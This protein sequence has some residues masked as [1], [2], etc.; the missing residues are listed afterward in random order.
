MKISLLKSHPQTEYILEFLERNLRKIKVETVDEIDGKKTSDEVLV[1]INGEVLTADTGYHMLKEIKSVLKKID[2]KKFDE[3]D[4][5]KFKKSLKAEKEELLNTDGQE[6]EEDGLEERQSLY[7]QAG[8]LLETAGKN[9]YLTLDSNVYDPEITTI[10]INDG[11]NIT[12]YGLEDLSR[13]V[14]FDEKAEEVEE[15]DKDQEDKENKEN[16]EEE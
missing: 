3:A 5:K 13:L 11:E 15:V 10:T 2:D 12:E 4:Y 1:K 6:S 9:I 8:I 16:K 7:S 14:D